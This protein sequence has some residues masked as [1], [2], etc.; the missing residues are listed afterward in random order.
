ML[1]T[2]AVLFSFFGL[3]ASPVANAHGLHGSGFMEGLVHP[4]LGIDHLLAML[5]MGVSVAAMGVRW[6]RAAASTMV[7]AL[8]LGLLSADVF[9]GTLSVDPLLAATLLVMGLIL[10]RKPVFSEPLRIALIACFAY[11]HGIAHGLGWPAQDALWPFVSGVASASL[12]LFVLGVGI[13]RRWMARH[14]RA[15]RGLGGLLGMA[16]LGFLFGA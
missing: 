4:V 1:K 5:A 8:S 14:P 16:G 15:Q 2:Q 3:L 10:L 9:R 12:V 13:G 7:L 11:F 6:Q